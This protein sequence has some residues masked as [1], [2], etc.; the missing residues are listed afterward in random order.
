MGTANRDRLEACLINGSVEMLS[1]SH[2]FD[3]NLSILSDLSSSATL[4]ALILS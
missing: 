1:G 4:Y 2:G 3:S